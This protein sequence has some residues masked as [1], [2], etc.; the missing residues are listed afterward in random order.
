MKPYHGAF[1]DELKK[2]YKPHI[3]FKNRF[4]FYQYPFLEISGFSWDNRG[5][6]ADEFDFV[7][8]GGGTSGLVVASRLSEDPNTL[9]LIVEAGADHREDP[10]VRTPAF[11]SFIEKDG[12]RLG[13]QD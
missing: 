1:A 13:F 12:S 7:I 3:A 9:V 6:M 5:K 2:L 8:V 11:A 4:C 10:R